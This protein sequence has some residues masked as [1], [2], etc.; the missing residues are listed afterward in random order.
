MLDRSSGALHVRPSSELKTTPLPVPQSPS[1]LDACLTY[2]SMILPDR[3]KV[4]VGLPTR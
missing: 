1:Q 2:T 3:V 4:A